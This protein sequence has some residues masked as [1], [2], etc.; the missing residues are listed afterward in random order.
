MQ[1]QSDLL[2][3]ILSINILNRLLVAIDGPRLIVVRI[4]L[5]GH[6]DSELIMRGAVA[7]LEFD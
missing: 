3:V 5:I 4:L 7:G 1:R 6:D 2:L